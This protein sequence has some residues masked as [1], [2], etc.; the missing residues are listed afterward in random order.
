MAMRK[1]PEPPHLAVDSLD[2]LLRQ[3]L[4]DR[5]GQPAAAHQQL[6]DALGTAEVQT[7]TPV[8]ESPEMVA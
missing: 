7:A 3:V 5:A 8:Q 4:Q 2:D 1:W 6:P